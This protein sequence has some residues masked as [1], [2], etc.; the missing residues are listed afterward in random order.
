MELGILMPDL[1][2]SNTGAVTDSWTCQQL[3][4]NA[5]QNLGYDVKDPEE[6]KTD[7]DEV[8]DETDGK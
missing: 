8:K 3:V 4:Q 5:T 2:F 7:Q 6:E 1:A